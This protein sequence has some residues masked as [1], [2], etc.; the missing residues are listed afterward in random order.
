VCLQFAPRL[1]AAWTTLKGHRNKYSS[2]DFGRSLH[3]QQQQACSPQDAP[4]PI[5]HS[6]A[7]A[8]AVKAD[9]AAMAHASSTHRAHQERE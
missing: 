5:R 6:S 9:S 3:Q 2:A 8:A 1:A 4:A 7:A